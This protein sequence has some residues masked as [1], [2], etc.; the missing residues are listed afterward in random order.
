MEGRFS[1]ADHAMSRESNTLVS[2]SRCGSACHI[3]AVTPSETERSLVFQILSQGTKSIPPGNGLRAI[4]SRE[5]RWY[6]N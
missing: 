3:V 4:F 2:S 5:T 6:L 1:L